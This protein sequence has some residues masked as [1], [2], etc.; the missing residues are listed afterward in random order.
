MKQ[1]ETL[2]TLLCVFTLEYITRRA[3]KLKGL[4]LTVSGQ[5]W[6]SFNADDVN[7]LNENTAQ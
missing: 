3:N 6:L 2:S 1:G 4:E 5:Q 7:I